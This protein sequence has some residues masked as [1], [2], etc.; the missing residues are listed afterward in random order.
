MAISFTCSC[1]KAFKAKDEH[2][3]RRAICP[4]CRREF[5]VPTPGL[6]LDPVVPEALTQVQVDSEDDPRLPAAVPVAQQPARP[7]EQRHHRSRWRGRRRARP[8]RT[9]TSRRGDRSGRTR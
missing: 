9:H 8:P 4:A 3:G 6:D 2:A 7:R 1:G 5:V